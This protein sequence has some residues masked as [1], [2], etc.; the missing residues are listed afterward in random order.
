MEKNKCVDNN[1][2]K[3]VVGKRAWTDRKGRRGKRIGMQGTGMDRD[4]ER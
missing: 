4:R 2:R 3:K 1:R